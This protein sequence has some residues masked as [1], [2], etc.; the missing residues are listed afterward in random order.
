MPR[1]KLFRGTC[2]KLL[3]H[4]AR[5]SPG[6]TTLRV[7]LNR[8]R[9]VKI[10]KGVSIG[11][12]AVIETGHPYLVTLK[13]RSAIGIRATIIAHHYYPEE[14]RG[15][16]VE[17]D[18]TVGVGAIVLANVV[19]GKGALVTA[20]SV[21]TKSVPPLTM[22]QGNPAVPIARMDIPFRPT[23]S[24]KEFSRHLKPIP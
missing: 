19:I 7:W 14:T 2:N 17:E 13:D 15:V 16:V 5:F 1:D 9:G 22:V 24:M 18:A 23:I 20:G 12:D 21:V 11:Y 8:W 3:Q 6:R 10:G 4:A